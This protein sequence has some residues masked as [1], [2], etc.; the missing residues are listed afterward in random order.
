MRQ[1]PYWLKSTHM[2]GS[3]FDNNVSHDIHM[4][5]EIYKAKVIMKIIS[6]ISTVHAITV[7]HVILKLA[8]VVNSDKI[9]FL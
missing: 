4:Y 8:G 2:T 1:C 9:Q 6:D 3:N 7:F 5:T